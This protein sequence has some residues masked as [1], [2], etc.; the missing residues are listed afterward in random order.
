MAETWSKNVRNQEAHSASGG[1]HPTRAT[2]AGV[3]LHLELSG[4]RV[5]L[6]LESALRDAVRTGRLA[7]AT[8]LP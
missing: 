3:D 8:R 1:Q 6:G 5:R 7:P 2:L 4:T